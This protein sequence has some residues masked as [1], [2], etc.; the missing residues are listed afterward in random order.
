LKCLSSYQNTQYSAGLLIWE[1]IKIRY[2]DIMQFNS[3]TKRKI[4]PPDLKN[5]SA[6]YIYRYSKKNLFKLI[7]IF[8]HGN[9]FFLWL[10]TL[11]MIVTE[12]LLYQENYSFFLSP[13][14]IK[15]VI[16]KVLLSYR[17]NLLN[18]KNQLNNNLRRFFWVS[19]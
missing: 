1:F 18:I 4:R 15:S 12:T 16:L 8:F 7:F 9:F 14:T 11:K 6:I 17:N 3:K 10:Q 13:R 2:T 5:D 19:R